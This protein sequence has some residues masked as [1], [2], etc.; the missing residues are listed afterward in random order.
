MRLTLELDARLLADA[1]RLAAEAGQT[2]EHVIEMS[3]REMIAR[4]HAATKARHAAGGHP[5]PEGETILD[6]DDA[7]PFPLDPGVERDRHDD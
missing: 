4:H 5:T 7:L 6:V 2:L 3:L 1:K